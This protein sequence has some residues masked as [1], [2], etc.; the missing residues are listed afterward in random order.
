VHDEG[1]DPDAVAAAVAK[2]L[3]QQG[4]E[5]ILAQVRDA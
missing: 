1:P 5:S 4:A 3:I 2:A